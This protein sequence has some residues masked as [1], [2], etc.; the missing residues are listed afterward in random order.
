MTKISHIIGA[1]STCL[2]VFPITAS[3]AP[4]V[5]L[6]L[7]TGILSYDIQ[8]AGSA[9]TTE[10]GLLRKLSPQSAIGINLHFFNTKAELLYP[11]RNY[12]TPELS[13]KRNYTVLGV[14]AFSKIG[15]GITVDTQWQKSHEY[16]V[17]NYQLNPDGFTYSVETQRGETQLD[18]FYYHASL[19]SGLMF[20]ISKSSRLLIDAN[21][22]NYDVSS[23]S[24]GTSASFVIDF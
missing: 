1:A 24:L 12:F 11:E 8:G 3:S 6:N 18:P 10:I 9:R 5:E 14:N 2:I 16:Y 22:R 13:Y 15:V 17:N 23:L 19:S 21:I 20:D 4:N 7:G